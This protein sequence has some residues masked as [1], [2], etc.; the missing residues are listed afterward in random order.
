MKY[1]IL[2]LY[3][4][5]IFIVSHNLN[6]TEIQENITLTSDISNHFDGNNIVSLARDNFLNKRFLSYF[7]N[8]NNDAIVVALV[9]VSSG[10][11]GN[12]FG[13]YLEVLA[14]SI[15]SRSHFIG[16]WLKGYPK[17]HTP[18]FKKI[19]LI[20]YD[21]NVSTL[22]DAIKHK[23]QTIEIPWEV[24]E[25]K[26]F[27]IIHKIKSILKPILNDYL[28]TS[29]QS[30]YN[31]IFNIFLQSNQID[32][33]NLFLKNNGIEFPNSFD[34]IF[35][36]TEKYN[37]ELNYKPNQENIESLNL[38]IIPDVIIQLRCNDVAAMYCTLSDNSL[39]GFFNFYVY[40]PLIPKDAKTI[41]IS[42]NGQTQHFEVC[43]GISKALVVF[44]SM[45]FPNAIILVFIG[46]VEDT[47][48]QFQYSKTVICSSSTF[49]FYPSFANTNRVYFP[50]SLLV[51]DGKTYQLTSSWNWIMSYNNICIGDITNSKISLTLQK[52]LVL[53]RL[54]NSANNVSTICETSMPCM[55]P[56]I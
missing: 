45:M 32:E 14:S 4:Y 20:R 23:L 53:E 22:N 2:C 1:I 24:P 10:R 43:K 17:P 19:P 7:P 49:C 8:D 48:L 41:Y 52:K 54:L 44:L 47:L 9:G 26:G 56:F 40:L 27:K 31:N 21:K 30:D 25:A 34:K 6:L 11:F 29:Y 37:K 38:M 33:S 51:V 28:I 5:F 18:W 36:F 13:W 35:N 46:H 3:L 42:T 15:E 12:Y 16:I 55:I 39:Y 50:Q